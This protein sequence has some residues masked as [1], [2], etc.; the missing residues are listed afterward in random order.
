MIAYGT[1]IHADIDFGLAFSPSGAFG[2]ELTLREGVPPDIGLALT[3]SFPFIRSHGRDIRLYNDREFSGNEAEQPWCFEI[4]GVATFCWRGGQSTIYYNMA[5]GGSPERLGF[6]F[7]HQLLPLFLAL[8]RVYG[9]LHAGAVE[10]GG[11]AVLFTA[12]S[13][14]GKSTLTDYFLSRGHALIS[15][16]KVAVTADMEIVPSHPYHRPYRQ[17]ETLGR[18]AARVSEHML[19]PAAV[20][21]LSP[22][23]AHEAPIITEVTGYA[24]FDA[25][26]PSLMYLFAQNRVERLKHLTRFL[27]DVFVCRIALPWALPRLP[28]VYDAIAAHRQIVPADL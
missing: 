9:F 20:Y 11:E 19:K 28:D 1:K 26:L 22:L 10:I 14:G 15:D 25:L 6:W 21:L 17:F 2:R 5:P 4:E 24:K 3:E 23:P 27:D 13:M 7:V 8:E 18:R 12:P 16:D